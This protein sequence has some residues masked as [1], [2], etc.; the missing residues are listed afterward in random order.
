MADPDT[1]GGGLEPLPFTCEYEVGVHEAGDPEDWEHYHPKA[2]TTEQARKEAVQLA[3][4]DGMADP[5]VYMCT[6]PYRPEDPIRVGE[7]MIAE[8]FD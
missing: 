5:V 8:V 6:G 1:D 7:E 2:R 4:G 3:F